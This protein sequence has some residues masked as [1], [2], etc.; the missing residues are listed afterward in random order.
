M[1]GD[2]TYHEMGFIELSRK[3]SVPIRRS[4]EVYKDKDWGGEI[5]GKID[6]A[7]DGIAEYG[8]EYPNN[9][10]KW[11]NGFLISQNP[12]IDMIGSKPDYH[13][14]S[15]KIPIG[16][17]AHPASTSS[18]GGEA[19]YVTYWARNRK[20]GHDTYNSNWAPLAFS[21]SNGK[22]TKEPRG[23]W[24]NRMLEKLPEDVSLFCNG[25]VEET[26]GDK[27]LKKCWV[28]RT[29]LVNNGKDGD[30][31]TKLS[32]MD[33]SSGVHL[34]SFCQLGDNI[35]TNKLCVDFCKENFNTPTFCRTA[36]KRLCNKTAFKTSHPEKGESGKKYRGND[37]DMSKQGKSGEKLKNW[38]KEDT[39]CKNYCGV[40][41]WESANPECSKGFVEYCGQSKNYNRIGQ[42]MFCSKLLKKA[43]EGDLNIILHPKR[44]GRAATSIVKACG[45]YGEFPH[46]FSKF[47]NSLLR[48]NAFV[49]KCG[50]VCSKLKAD[51]FDKKNSYDVFC[52]GARAQFCNHSN[53][54]MQTSHCLDFC[55]EFPDDCKKGLTNFCKNVKKSANSK[56]PNVFA[57]DDMEE[58]MRLLDK[59][60]KKET[61][62][63]KLWCGCSAPEEYYDDLKKTTMEHF[64]ISNYEFRDLSYLNN[65]RCLGACQ[66]S[67]VTPSEIKKKDKCPDCIVN[68]LT[69]VGT[70]DNGKIIN[71]IDAECQGIISKKT[72]PERNT[73]YSV[74]IGVVSVLIIIAVIYFA[75]Y[76]GKK[77]KKR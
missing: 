3:D 75:Q 1:N 49:G 66:A 69:N 27:G 28:G 13:Y 68:V 35:S 44:L 54:N 40:R 18:S 32:Q 67:R 34:P 21:K 5:I 64:R 60:F 46:P 37:Y 48:D 76:F 15:F 51:T 77:Q 73:F 16:M 43:G 33:I 17:W 74:M 45:V 29:D 47:Q 20:N 36:K 53:A 12:K 42:G 6:N 50:K 39:V 8:K 56:K 63:I 31:L 23:Y 7:G 19:N 71:N 9:R 2:P 24:D 10:N 25:G 14:K 38:F 52:R 22:I 58:E 26:L 72:G 59:P 57:G 4:F 70:L 41:P 55:S 30:P 11:E 62:R 65:K 61:R